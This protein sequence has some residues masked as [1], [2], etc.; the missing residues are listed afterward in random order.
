MESHENFLSREPHALICIL[1]R[2]LGRPSGP[3][4]RRERA[5]GRK[6]RVTLRSIGDNKSVGRE[7]E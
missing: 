5:G 7:W 4:L 2:E 1:E 6:T 3:W